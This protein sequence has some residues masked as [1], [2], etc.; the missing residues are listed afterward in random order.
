MFGK[1]YN[2]NVMAL[3]GIGQGWLIDFD[4]S[5]IP[6]ALAL[7][8]AMQIEQHGGPE[9]DDR[10]SLGYW[11]NALAKQLI[12]NEGDSEEPRKAYK[13]MTHI[14]ATAIA[15]MESMQRN[16]PGIEDEVCECPNCTKRREGSFDVGA[17][18]SFELD[19][20]PSMLRGIAEVGEIDGVKMKVVVIDSPEQLQEVLG[21]LMN[22]KL[23]GAR[24]G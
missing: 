23:P 3:V 24:P 5:D 2:P 12:R 15:A 6:A 21:S 9:V 7:T 8:R 19:R 4:D 1:I 18:V 20:M 14:A 16:F 11:N 17:N 22:G 10:R 13:R